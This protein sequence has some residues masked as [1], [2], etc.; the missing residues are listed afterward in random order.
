MKTSRFIIFWLSI[1]VLTTIFNQSVHAHQ[2]FEKG[3]KVEVQLTVN[4]QDVWVL[5]IYEKYKKGNHIV[6]YQYNIEGWKGGGEWQ[7]FSDQD[8]RPY[9]DTLTTSF[10]AAD[11]NA[12]TTIQTSNDKSLQ[13]F[14]KGQQVEIN[15]IVNGQEVWIEGIY[16]VYYGG[17]H[18]VSYKYD[19]DGWNGYGMMKPFGDNQ[20]R[21]YTGN[22]TSSLYEGMLEKSF[23]E[24]GKVEIQVLI[25]GTK[26]WVVGIYNTAYEGKHRVSY[27]YNVDGW[28]GNG[29]NMPF[30]DEEIRP[31]TGNVTKTL[32]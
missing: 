14:E 2:T 29:N 26:A 11:S 1:I 30:S 7:S 10:L 3:D 23:E 25:N 6:H 20:I 17:A 9:E 19:I 12:E 27:K 32:N 24:G 28:T 21:S 31:Y 22:V 18:R 16:D 13:Q 4:D 15:I 5:G 8:I